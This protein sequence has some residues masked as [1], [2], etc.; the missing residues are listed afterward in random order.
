MYSI[1]KGSDYR[2]SIEIQTS[3]KAG[4]REFFTEKNNTINLFVCMGL[5]A[6]TLFA[7][8]INAYYSNYFPGDQFQNLILISTVELIAYIISGMFF[9]S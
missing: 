6:V 2:K 8:M 3:V 5:W 4:I 1:L 9:D 7:Y